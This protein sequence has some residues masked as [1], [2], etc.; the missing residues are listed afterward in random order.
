MTI[1]SVRSLFRSDAVGSLMGLPAWLLVASGLLIGADGCGQGNKPTEVTGGPAAS[2]S[3]ASLGATSGTS[4]GSTAPSQASSTASPSESAHGLPSEISSADVTESGPPWFGLP[5]QK[6]D[7]VA[8]TID[9]KD[10]TP[11][12][13]KTATVRGH[14]TI[15]GAAPPDALAANG[16]PHEFP[17][18]CTDAPDLYGKLFRKGAHGELADAMVAI[19]EYEGFVPPKARARSL[20]IRN[21]AL[22]T[23]T[24]VA[25]FGQ[26]I[27]VSNKDTELTYMPYLDGAPFRALMVAVPRGK[28]IKLYPM[29]PGH[30][31]LRDQLKRPFLIADVFVLPYATFDVTRTD[32]RYEIQGVPVGKVRIDAFLPSID[33]S[34]GKEIEI[35][36]GENVVD[37]ELSYDPKTDKPVVVPEPIWGDRQLAH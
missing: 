30:Y 7:E 11:Y 24:I 1:S 2:Q 35:K 25:T 15:K 26:R 4:S 6:K 27:E 34:V 20:E 19:T 33:K 12:S 3:A 17:K 5:P 28:P 22:N 29:Q 14:I 13:G 23:R 8:K 9:P 31:L 18:E 36:E 16:K 10:E 37:L 21:C 32:G